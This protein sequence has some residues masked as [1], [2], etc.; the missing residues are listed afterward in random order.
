MFHYKI[1]GENLIITQIRGYGDEDSVLI[2]LKE[3]AEA[4]KPLIAAKP[5]AKKAT[6][7]EA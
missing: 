4:L 5:R 7:D 3:L 2:P 6:K 1:D